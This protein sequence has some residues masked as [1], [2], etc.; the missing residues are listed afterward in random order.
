MAAPVFRFADGLA[1]TQDPAFGQSFSDPYSAPSLQVPW[2]NVLGNHDYGDGAPPGDALPSDCAPTDQGCYFSPVHQVRSQTPHQAQCT[3]C[4]N[5]LPI[6]AGCAFA[7]L[8]L[9]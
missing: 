5:T 6:F 9:N 3:A 8:V 2:Y 4:K 7:F 1:S